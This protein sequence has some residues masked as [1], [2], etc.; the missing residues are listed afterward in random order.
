M[1]SKARKR[2]RAASI[3][4]F[5]STTITVLIWLVGLGAA[6]SVTN[7]GSMILLPGYVN[8]PSKLRLDSETGT[9]S[10]EKG[11]TLSYD[12]G[13][14]AGVYTE[15]QWCDWTKGEVWRKE[16]KI[17]GQKAIFVF[18]ESKMLVVIFP[19]ASTPTSTPL[20]I[21][22]AILPTFCS[23]SRLLGRRDNLPGS[24]ACYAGM[25]ISVRCERRWMRSGNER[26]GGGMRDTTPLELWEGAAAA[27]GVAVGQSAE[28]RGCANGKSLIAAAAQVNHRK[29]V[30]SFR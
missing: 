18:T 21:R 15:C 7:P 24:G 2:Q 3:L 10:N 29:P 11:L 25:S 8:T 4:F 26:A 20:S 17:N 28:T 9:I 16:Q 27:P 12:I 22:K 5:L 30:D 19:E 1:Y 6:Q 23:C 14:D 13:Q